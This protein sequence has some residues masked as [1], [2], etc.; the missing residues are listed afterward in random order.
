MRPGGLFEAGSEGN[1]RANPLRAR[2][3]YFQLRFVQANRWNLVRKLLYRENFALSPK[4]T[5]Y[6]DDYTGSAVKVMDLTSNHGQKFHDASWF[7]QAFP[8][9]RR[10]YL[11]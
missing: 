1:Y 7:K 3:G 9:P 2:L 10:L 4:V 5:N 6:A 8:I 11:F